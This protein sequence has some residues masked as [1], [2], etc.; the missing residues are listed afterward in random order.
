MEVRP[1]EADVKGFNSYIGN[2]IA[3]LPVEKAAVESKK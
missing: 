1:D 2:Y 3:C